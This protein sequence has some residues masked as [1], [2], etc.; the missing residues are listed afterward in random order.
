MFLMFEAGIDAVDNHIEEQDEVTL[1]GDECNGRVS[2]ATQQPKYSPQKDAESAISCWNCGAMQ[3]S[4]DLPVT[5]T[6]SASA[7]RRSS[8]PSNGTRSVQVKNIRK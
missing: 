7:R 2:V 8:L 4:K 5:T 6:N 3:Y 1:S